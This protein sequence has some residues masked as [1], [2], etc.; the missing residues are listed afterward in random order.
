MKK[1]I[2]AF[3]G[4][5]RMIIID[6]NVDLKDGKITIRTWPYVE[7]RGKDAT[8]GKM[9]KLHRFI[10]GKEADGWEIDHVDK[11]PLNNQLSN[12]KLVTKQQ[13]RWNSKRKKNSTGMIGV[14]K[15]GSKYHALMV[16]DGKKRYL[17]TFTTAEAAGRWYDEVCKRK[18]GEFA[19]LNFKCCKMT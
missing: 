5:D 18:R 15:K 3:A 1:I 9:V 13:N 8:T 19:L 16:F 6:D 7:I 2:I 14:Q 12:L 10:I 4:L 17:G 11:N